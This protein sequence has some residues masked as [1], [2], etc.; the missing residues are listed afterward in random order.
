MEKLNLINYNFQTKKPTLRK[1]KK[2]ACGVRSNR[3]KSFLKNKSRSFHRF[4]IISH[5]QNRW[6]TDSLNQK[7]CRK[8]KEVKS[9]FKT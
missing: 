1:P 2:T 9:I 8:D 3:M 6:R 5:S 7:V 4:W